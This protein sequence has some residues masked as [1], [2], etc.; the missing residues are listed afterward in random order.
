MEKRREKIVRIGKK[1]G[2]MAKTYHNVCKRQQIKKIWE[3]PLELMKITAKVVR[4]Y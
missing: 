4:I 1:A 2:K 3:N